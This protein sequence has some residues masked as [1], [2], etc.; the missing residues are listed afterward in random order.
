MPAPSSDLAR[1]AAGVLLLCAGAC[2]PYDVLASGHDVGCETDDWSCGADV[3]T[4]RETDLVWERRAPTGVFTWDEAQA[5]CAGL[6]LVDRTGWRVPTLEE[7]LTIREGS[8]SPRIDLG[9]FPD[10]E[11]GW[12]WAAGAFNTFS[13]HAVDFASDETS[14]A[15]LKSEP[16]SVRCVR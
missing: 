10:T 7:L 16:S 12:F 14:E 2:G 9:V 11:G 5:R 13:A 3:A 6:R 1:L 15:R 4:H 8:L